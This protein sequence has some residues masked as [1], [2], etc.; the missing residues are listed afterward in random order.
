MY[1]YN[2]DLNDTIYENFKKILNNHKRNKLSINIDLMKYIINFYLLK[3]IKVF[4]NFK[5]SK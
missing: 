3:K 4:L 2:L 1:E 5:L